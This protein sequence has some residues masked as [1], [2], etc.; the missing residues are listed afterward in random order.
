M[1]LIAILLAGLELA[2]ITFALALCRAAAKR[3]LYGPPLTPTTPS[4]PETE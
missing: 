3:P 4:N 1:T 2:G